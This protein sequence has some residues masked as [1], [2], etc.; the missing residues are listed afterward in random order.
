[1][2]IGR[3]FVEDA[4]KQIYGRDLKREIFTLIDLSSVMNILCSSRSK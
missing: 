2:D 4:S 3:N 1:M